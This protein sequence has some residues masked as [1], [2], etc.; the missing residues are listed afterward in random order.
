MI[1][2]GMVGSEN[3]HSQIFSGYMNLP[4]R[5]GSRPLNA[6]VVSIWGGDAVRTKEVAKEKEIPEIVAKPEDMLGKIDAVM[7]VPRRGSVHLRHAEPFLKAGLPAWIDKPFTVDYE[8]ALTIVK[9]A[10]ESGSMI[11]GGSVCKFCDDVRML[12]RMFQKM[13]DAGEFISGTFNF[14]GDINCQYDGIY[15]YGAHS[16]EMLLTIFG[17]NIL[18]ITTNVHKN[19]LV[20]I[21]KYPDFTV[22]MNFSATPK[23]YC[24][25]YGSK[26][27]AVRPLDITFAYYDA[28]CA[29]VGMLSKKCPPQDISEL[30]RSVRV[31]NALDE[32]IKYNGAETPVKPI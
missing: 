19:N 15:F 14:P 20:A 2:V 18:S 31:L 17:S 7:V 3:T 26:E 30:L 16:V 28:V 12:R 5:D 4:L 27:T 25:L 11:C 13:H 6:R 24:T 8:E 23:S 21:A 9:L 22:T 32:S 29:F 1:R 10:K